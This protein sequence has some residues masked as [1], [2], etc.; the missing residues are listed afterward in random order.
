MSEEN[1]LNGAS[2][3]YAVREGAKT[4]VFRREIYLEKE[5]KR[6]TI[7]ICG[8]GQF[9]LFVQGTE[10]NY[11]NLEP[12]W[13]NYR[14]TCLYSTYDITKYLTLGLNSITVLIGNGMYHIDGERYMKFTGTFGDPTMV[15]EVNMT[16]EDGTK[17]E[18]VSDENWLYAESPITHSCI[19]GGEDFD[20]RI[21]AWKHL[22]SKNQD[23]WRKVLIGEGPGGILKP[24]V[25]P[26]VIIQ[27]YLLPISE[28]RI[29][30]RKTLFDFGRNFAGKIKITVKGKA[31]QQ[32][33][34]IPGELLL[35]NHDINQEFTGDP[36]YYQYTLSGTE[37]EEWMPR[38]T[39]YGQRYG[40]IETDV[41]DI[42]VEGVETFADCKRTGK[43]E[44]SNELY[45]KIHGLIVGA[46]ESNMQSV[47]TDCPHRE[48]L[49]W[50]EETHLIGQGILNNF[51]AKRLYEK[52]LNDM[53]DSQTQS[54][55]VPNICPEFVEFDKGFR[56]SPEW[57]SACVILPWYLYER[58]GDKNLLELHYDLSKKYVNY[59]LGKSK[60][61]ILN[62]GLG[63]WLDVGHYPVHPANTPIPITATAILY[64]DLLL[65]KETAKALNKKVDILIYEDHIC[66]AK[67]AYNEAFFY[68]LSGNY[69]NGSQTANAM[70]LFLDLVPKP[71]YNRV[72]KNLLED[73]RLKE[74]HLTGGD[75][76]HPFTLR[77]LEKCGCSDVIAKILM[78][79]DFP[80]YGF[81][82]DCG[83]TTLCEDWDGPNT[84][85]PVMSQNHFMLGGAEEWFYHY[86][87]GI[88]VDMKENILAFE[89]NFVNEVNWVNCE[90]STVYGSA[91][92]GWER[93]GKV[94]IIKMII[95]AGFKVKLIL[96]GHTEEISDHGEVWRS[97]A[98]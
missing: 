88:K 54:G 17:I 7:S 13:T 24:A 45:N 74:G 81:Q 25:Q 19:F 56:D 28:E 8:L 66:K 47:F 27:K 51:N 67:K 93:K 33:K 49:G 6:A 61:Y 90:I 21:N 11:G 72:L 36:H 18:F 89:P 58:Y 76:G 26:P 63:D 29:S 64:Y 35:E 34:I 52:I 41:E 73:I 57:G 15:A 60:E 23:G 87:A 59:L 84:E 68:D 20:S 43:F 32:V 85:H 86:L 96:N 1:K 9:S 70:A 97:M 94:V 82:V 65:M 80:S 39:Y 5:V 79:R 83:A 92:I 31:G 14:K 53:E 22:V 4:P 55:L 40:L 16:F 12:G 75:V 77:A 10:I 71:E 42:K 3:I 48:K 50:L 38:F 95:P 69:S 62:Y 98:K 37:Q 44:C 46:I 2:W 91:G 78:K 30:E